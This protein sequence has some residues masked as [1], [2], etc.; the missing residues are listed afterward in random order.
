VTHPFRRQSQSWKKR[1]ESK[2]T[3]K[4]E[5]NF[6]KRLRENT[7]RTTSTYD[8]IDFFRMTHNVIHTIN[9]SNKKRKAI[10]QLK[11]QRMSERES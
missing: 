9:A 4:M 6:K 11:R 5:E 3:V 8:H 7:G 2:Q 10:N 1:G